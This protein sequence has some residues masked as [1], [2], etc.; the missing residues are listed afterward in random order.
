MRMYCMSHTSAPGRN[1]SLSLS[2]SEADSEA[3]S[4]ARSSL[5]S[6]LGSPDP[7]ADRQLG[8]RLRSRL[9]IRC[10][11][12]SGCLRQVPPLPVVSCPL[13]LLLVPV[14][15]SLSL[16]SFP[17]P[18]PLPPSPFPSLPSPFPSLPSPAPHSAPPLSLRPSLPP[19]IA[20]L[21]EN[22]A[23]LLRHCV[24]ALFAHTPQGRVRVRTG[25]ARAAWWTLPWKPAAAIP[26]F[27]VRHHD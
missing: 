27:H 26:A 4:H 24:R 13:S 22:L 8:S 3:D 14:S 7:A 18:L 17:L 21:R 9:G 23:C 6:S 20:F 12:A 10:R 2:D 15:P 1:L 19:F 5:G 16:L 25:R 11:L